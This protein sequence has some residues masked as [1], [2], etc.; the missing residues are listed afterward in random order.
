VDVEHILYVEKVHLCKSQL[1]L[2]VPGGL[3][4]Q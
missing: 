4:Y 2:I 3:I 1:T